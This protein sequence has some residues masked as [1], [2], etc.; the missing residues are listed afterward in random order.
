MNKNIKL[1]LKNNF[2]YFL[3]L[4]ELGIIDIDI[5]CNSIIE[6]KEPDYILE[7]A[8]RLGNKRNIRDLEDAIIST[9][10]AQ[11]IYAFACNV[12]STDI[13]K[14]EDALKVLNEKNKIAYI[15]SKFK[16]SPNLIKLLCYL[17]NEET[18]VILASKETYASLFE[19]DK[20]VTRKLEK[21]EK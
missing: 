15:N 17:E 10:N 4:V 8:R 12:E 2:E 11:Y 9:H 6:Y 21:R 13:I 19:E 5:A 1:L 7:F 18:D 20:V 14:L 3:K 16:D